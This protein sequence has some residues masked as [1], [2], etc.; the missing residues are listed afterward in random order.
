MGFTMNMKL[1]DIE[2]LIKDRGQ[3]VEYCMRIGFLHKLYLKSTISKE[4][5]LKQRQRSTL[6]F[7]GIE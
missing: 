7:A 1:Q 6:A 4:E 5:Y 2:D 3:W